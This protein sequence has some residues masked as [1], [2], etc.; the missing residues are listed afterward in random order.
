MAGT[1]GAPLAVVPVD[2][3]QEGGDRVSRRREEVAFVAAGP[4]QRL[5]GFLE[6]TI[7]P[8]AEGCD[9]EPIGYIEGSYVDAAARRRAFGGRLVEAAKDGRGSPDAW[10]WGPMASPRT[11]SVSEPIGR[12]AM[13][14][15]NGSFI[16][17]KG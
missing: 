5:C 4:S 6:A 1:P 10:R 15:G 9:T 14:T 2:R 11:G 12:S 17:G 7:R 8:F 3:A 13:K 16:S